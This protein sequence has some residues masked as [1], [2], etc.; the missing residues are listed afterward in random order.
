MNKEIEKLIKIA[1]KAI[2]EELID[3]I[4]N[5]E[6]REKLLE[7]LKPLKVNAESFIKSKV[8]KINKESLDEA[9]EIALEKCTKKDNENQIRIT[10]FLTSLYKLHKI[11]RGAQVGGSLLKRFGES[12]FPAIKKRELS[13]SFDVDRDIENLFYEKLKEDFYK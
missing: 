11:E 5:K 10:A 12:W 1:T 4:K 2:F 3:I 13:Y 9:I 8:G 6:K 7:L